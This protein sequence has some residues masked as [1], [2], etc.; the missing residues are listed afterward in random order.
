MKLKVC[1]DI[2]MRGYCRFQFLFYYFLHFFDIPHDSSTNLSNNLPTTTDSFSNIGKNFK[3]ESKKSPD[4]CPNLFL[5]I[6]PLFPWKSCKIIFNHIKNHD[7]KF[8]I[9]IYYLFSNLFVGHYCCK[10]LCYC[11]KFFIIVFVQHTKFG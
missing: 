4:K 11:W 6:Q 3:K 10:Y 5:V 2:L 1:F 7:N 9:L 8:M